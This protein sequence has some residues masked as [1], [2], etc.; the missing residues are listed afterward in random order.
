MLI[1]SKSSRIEI[2][3]KISRMFHRLAPTRAQLRCYDVA[4]VQSANHRFPRKKLI[5]NRGEIVLQL[6]N[7][8]QLACYYYTQPLLQTSMLQ[9]TAA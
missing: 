8:I 3:C 2:S 1:G 7:D 6:R 4:D 5:K 9:L